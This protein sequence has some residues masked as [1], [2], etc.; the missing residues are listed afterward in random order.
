MTLIDYIILAAL[1]LIVVGILLYIRKEKKK[2][3]K[4]IGCPH[5]GKCSRDCGK[6][7]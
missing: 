6:S 7:K 5:G 1:A 4:C 3:T 2:G